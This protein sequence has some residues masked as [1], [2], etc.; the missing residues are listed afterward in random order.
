ME[1]NL[2]EAS[3]KVSSVTSENASLKSYEYL[4]E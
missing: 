2:D 1:I 4:N 3:P